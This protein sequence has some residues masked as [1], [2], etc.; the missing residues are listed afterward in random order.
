MS[1]GRKAPYRAIYGCGGDPID[2]D[3][4]DELAGTKINP[5]PL[6][7]HPTLEADTKLLRLALEALEQSETTVPYEGF[8]M[9]RRE[10]ER[11]HQ[12]A[13]AALRVRMGSAA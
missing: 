11:K 4:A 1:A 10:A 7:T 12:A 2:D 3:L 9:A 13:I 5:A 8:G 6:Y